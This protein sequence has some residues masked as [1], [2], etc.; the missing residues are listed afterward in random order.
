MAEMQH[1]LFTIT[2]TRGDAFF[3][4]MTAEEGT[5]MSAHFQYLKQALADGILLMAGPCLDRTFGVGL[6][7]A[8]SEAAARAFMGND[9][10]VRAGVQQLALHPFRL[11]LWAGKGIEQQRHKEKES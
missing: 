8:E 5:A 1:F 10:S 4:E 11:S 6:I 3:D 7:V 2:P 9:P